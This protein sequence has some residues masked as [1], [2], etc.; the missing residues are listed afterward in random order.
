VIMKHLCLCVHYV[1]LRRILS[2]IEDVSVLMSFA[3][4]V[5]YSKGSEFI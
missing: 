3:I 2:A 4:F 1:D 5:T